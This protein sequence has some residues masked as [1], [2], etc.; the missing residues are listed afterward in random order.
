LIN[1]TLYKGPL[2]ALFLSIEANEG[3]PN[4]TTL[5]RENVRSIELQAQAMIV[6]TD[7]GPSTFDLSDCQ[8]TERDKDAM[9]RILPCLRAMN[10]DGSIGLGSYNMECDIC[11]KSGAG[12]IVSAI[13]FSDAVRKGFNPFHN[14]C[15]PQDMLQIAAP[16]YPERWVLSATSGDTFRSD[17]NICAACM[18]KLSPYLLSVNPKASVTRKSWWQFWK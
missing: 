7:L 17:W 16:G 10:S 13:K 15:I 8:Y 3:R 5:I 2:S 6:T 4:P 11:S 14:G 9:T 1:G 12:T 18:V